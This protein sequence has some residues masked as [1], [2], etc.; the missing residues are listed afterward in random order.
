MPVLLDGFAKAYGA[1]APFGWFGWLFLLKSQ[2]KPKQTPPEGHK[3]KEFYLL[4]KN[5]W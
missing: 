5:L 4:K 1:A 3:I 2:K